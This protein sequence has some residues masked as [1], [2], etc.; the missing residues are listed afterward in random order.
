MK[1]IKFTLKL[2]ISSQVSHNRVPT[3]CRSLLSENKLQIVQHKYIFIY[4][5]WFFCQEIRG[6]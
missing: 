6:K 5:L 1:K 2:G 4:A 3:A